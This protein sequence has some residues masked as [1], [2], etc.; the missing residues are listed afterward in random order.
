LVVQANKT[1]F[2]A[3]VRAHDRIV[4][5]EEHKFLGA[6]LNNFSIKS[7]YGYYYN[8]YYYYSK[9]NGTSKKRVKS[10]IKSK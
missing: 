3:F 4:E 9:P 8:Y 6:V 7:A 10:Q 2:D 1:P 5:N